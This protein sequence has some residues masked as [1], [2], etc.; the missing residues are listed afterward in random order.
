MFALLLYLWVGREAALLEL[1]AEI[2]IG[3]A[4]TGG[5]GGRRLHRLLRPLLAPIRRRT[6]PAPA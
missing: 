2:S 4:V 5:G 3:L 6:A 1:L